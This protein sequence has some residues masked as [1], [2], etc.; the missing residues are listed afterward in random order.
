MIASEPCSAICRLIPDE[1]VIELACLAVLPAYQKQ[2]MG[3]TLLQFAETLSREKGAASLIVL[4]TQ[5]EHWFIEKGFEPIE[6]Q[7]LPVSK[8]EMYNF[9]RNSKALIKQL[10]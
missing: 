9:Q 8:Q 3:D 7:H 4:T 10:V 1:K 6:L 5:T 2:T